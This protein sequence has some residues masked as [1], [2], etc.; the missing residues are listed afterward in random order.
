M[1]STCIDC[2]NYVRS[3]FRVEHNAKDPKGPIRL[4]P[5]DWP[6]RT[7]NKE[8]SQSGGDR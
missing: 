8:P 2:H 7:F 4:I 3:A 1:T 5:T 6:G